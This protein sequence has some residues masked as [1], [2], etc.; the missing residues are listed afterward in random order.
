MSGCKRYYLLFFIFLLTS[1]LRAGEPYL[2]D[3]DWDKVKNYNEFQQDFFYLC[4]LLENCHPA[5]IEEIGREE[6][7]RQRHRVAG[8]LELVVEKQ[9]FALILQKFVSQLND[10]HTQ[11]YYEHNFG[12]QRIPLA[13]AWSGDDLVIANV[14]WGEN[15][16]LIG[17]RVLRLGK[18][19]TDSLESLLGSYVSAENKYWRRNKLSSLMNKVGF[20]LITGVIDRED[21][22]DVAV[23]YHGEEKILRLGVV[24]EVRW[25]KPKE[26]P[27]TSRQ[28]KFFSYRILPEDNVCYFQFNQFQDSQT[29]KV[30]HQAGLVSDNEYGDYQREVGIM[31]GDFRI[32]LERLFNDLLQSGVGNLVVDLRNNGGGNSILSN[33][34]YY[35]LELKEPLRSFTTSIKLS[36]LMRYYYPDTVDYYL[37]R[38]TNDFGINATLPYLYN[39]ELETKEDYF[40]VIANKESDFY[41]PRPNHRFAGNLIFLTSNRTFSSAG[42]MVTIAYDNGIGTIIGEPMG[43]KP[44]SYG[45]ILYFTLPNSKIEGG[46]SC[47]IFNRPLRSRS[48]EK[49]IIPDYPVKVD[50]YEK[51]IQG[52]DVVWEKALE[53]INR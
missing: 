34:F 8:S 14:N 35:H 4:K 36:Q 6:F 53:L 22:L 30:Y 7:T 43:Q 42:D 3:F 51:Y 24:T 50:L 20:L 9:D 19:K 47:K 44:T 10:G 39:L 49:T 33:Q 31:G 40:S 18:V 15:I 32:F 27:V 38:L 41:V 16:N 17:S 45:D 26:H 13:F 21:S 2:I 11:I 37:N 46:V 29:A 28:N 1:L 25:L 23:D 48:K 12:E 52:R 5:L